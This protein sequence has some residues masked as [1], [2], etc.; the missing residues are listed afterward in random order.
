MAKFKE[1]NWN[2]W[3]LSG[4]GSG[5]VGIFSAVE[6]EQYP[7]YYPDF[8]VLLLSKAN[9]NHSIQ[10]FFVVSS[11]FQFMLHVCYL[12]GKL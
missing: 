8:G 4:S 11:K 6:S 2:E 1:I 3:I 9:E 5:I 12:S 7:V 10:R